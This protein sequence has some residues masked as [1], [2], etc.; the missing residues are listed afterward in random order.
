MRAL[1][2]ILFGGNKMGSHSIYQAKKITVNNNYHGVVLS[3]EEE[4]LINLVRAR[5]KSRTLLLIEALI[6]EERHGILGIEKQFSSF[7]EV[8]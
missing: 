4:T 8:D 1:A 5:G 6:S 7:S 3:P 2:A